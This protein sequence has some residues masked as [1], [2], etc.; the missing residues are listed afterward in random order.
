MLSSRKGCTLNETIIIHSVQ[1]GPN[2]SKLVQIGTSLFFDQFL[3]FQ[4]QDSVNTDDQYNV[5]HSN[6]YTASSQVYIAAG[7]G[8]PNLAGA[9]SNLSGYNVIAASVDTSSHAFQSTN[10]TLGTENYQQQTQILSAVDP[11]MTRRQSTTMGESSCNAQRPHTVIL[12][13]FNVETGHQN[14]RLG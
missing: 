9:G 14:L 11:R 2:L 8:G 6:V 4:F 5:V 10:G 1:I 7:V 3:F 13:Y 12:E